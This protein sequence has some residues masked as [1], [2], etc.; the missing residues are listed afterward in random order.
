MSHLSRSE[1]VDLVDDTL[2]PACAAHVETCA[3]CREQAETFRAAL[4]EAMAVD[5]P[6]PSPLFW[7][8]FQARVREGVARTPRRSMWAWIRVAGY[9]PLAA[10]LVAVLAVG[11]AIFGGL[12]PG[13][14]ALVDP[15]AAPIVEPSGAAVAGVDFA[16][17]GI[18]QVL[19][20]ADSE[21]WAVLTAAAADVE[22]EEAHA[23]GMHV[24]SATI[25]R[26]VQRMSPAELNELGRLLQSELKH[27]MN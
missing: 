14:W 20:A 25:D 3:S 12:T 16:D 22:L 4:R 24:H 15:H 10:A 13:R 19:E 18:A 21:V 11:V 2:S 7:E 6:D 8:H 23:V 5:V 17:Q 27:S 9:A 26:A 1:I